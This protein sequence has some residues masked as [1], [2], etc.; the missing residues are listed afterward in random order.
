M[1]FNPL[2]VFPSDCFR[3]GRALPLS[4]LFVLLLAGCRQEESI[5]LNFAFGPDDSGTVAALIKDFC[6]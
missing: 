3:I 2:R 1:R 5:T 4:L 6:R